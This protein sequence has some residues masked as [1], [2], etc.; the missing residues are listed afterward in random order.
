MNQLKINPVSEP[1]NK[2]NQDPDRDNYE[3]IK[4]HTREPNGVVCI[5]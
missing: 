3:S 1:E 4:N 5:G 2:D